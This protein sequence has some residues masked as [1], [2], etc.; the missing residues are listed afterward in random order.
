MTATI[1]GSS[2]P[3]IP[4]PCRVLLLALTT[5]LSMLVCGSGIGATQPTPGSTTPPPTT[6][7]PPPT[8]ITPTP[9]PTLLTPTPPV[10]VPPRDT[11]TTA[12]VPAPNPPGQP[13]ST[14]GDSGESGEAECGV[15]E[16]AACVAG[17]IDGFFQRLAESAL[18]PL[19]DLLSQTLLSTPEPG[20]LPK[21]GELWSSSWELVL[22]MYGLLVTMSGI[23]LMTHET[24]H[25]RWGWRE[26]LPRLVAGFVAGA[27]SLLLAGK[28]IQFANGLTIALA[29]A[30]PGS[31]GA[32]LKDMMFVGGGSGTN[33][34]L[35]LMRNALVVVLVVLLLTYVVRV[36]ITVV[37]I[38]AAPLAMMCYALP[39][40][41]GIARWWWRAFGAC[42]AIQVAQSLVLI[43]GLRV[44]LS[45]GNWWFFGPTRSGLV[46]LIVALAMG[47]LL[48]KIPFWLLS[49]LKI[50]HGGMVTSIARGFVMYK[51]MGLLKGGGSKAAP[52]PRSR[53]APTPRR[54]AP[55]R[56]TGSGSPTN[57]YAKVKATRSGQ[58]MLPLR[59][60][61][62][63][64]PAPS[65]P[66]RIPHAASIPVAAPQGQ[67]LML[68][69]PQFHGGVNLGPAP[70]LG[71]NGQY[72]L[73][74][75]VPRITAP[76]PPPPTRVLKPPPAP[77]SSRPKQLAFDY[78]VPPV[79]DPY[80][81]IRPTSSG[82]YPLPI[83]IRRVPTPRT[84]IAPV[85]RTPSAP[86]PS[87]TSA[88]PP[89]ATP[90]SRSARRQLHLP[91]P[92]LPVRRRT[93]RR[94]PGKDSK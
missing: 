23:V 10:R 71:T 57:P 14:P 54:P 47:L 12:G 21:I 43:T 34:F 25:T 48:I 61:K 90:P 74:I 22:G 31:A 92:D 42:L 75:T 58:L 65:T 78:T 89:V 13:P 55:T 36:T 6:T 59:G 72:R 66:T 8:A 51:A 1:S 94:T 44:F 7:A 19:L 93:T 29:G 4:R 85:P 82:Q 73:P 38:V 16:I 86:P 33:L 35:S 46:S 17:A 28:A 30:G 64:P 80:A 41:E 77:R 52:V 24:L 69:L 60:V 88:P 53:P 79:P 91:L 50:G 2:P 18:N 62:R 87:R 76:V 3:R 20:D 49:A 11:P 68:P 70:L 27:M 26:L 63:V 15:S 83:E 32:A 56:T 67:Q 39:G 45:P 37:L 5:V 81:R 9:R 84:P 40:A